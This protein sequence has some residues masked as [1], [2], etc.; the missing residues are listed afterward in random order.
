MMMK[1]LDLDQLL[2]GA[3]A[4]VDRRFAEAYLAALNLAALRG[5][6]RAPKAGEGS[7]PIHRTTQIPGNLG[8]G[9]DETEIYFADF[10]EIVIGD[11]MKIEIDANGG[12]A[13]VDADGETVSAYQRDLTLMRAISDPLQGDER[14][15]G[16]RCGSRHRRYGAVQG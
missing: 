6:D 14:R 13:Y 5:G 16:F 2:G 9:G 10:W 15:F 1:R 4:A 7:Y 8:A 11:S 12:A 3:P